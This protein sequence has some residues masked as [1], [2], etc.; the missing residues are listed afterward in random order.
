[1]YAIIFVALFLT[2]ADR[3]LGVDS[4]L[5]P[6]LGASDGSQLVPFHR[7]IPAPPGHRTSASG[8]SARLVVARPSQQI[9][10]SHLRRG[11]LSGRRFQ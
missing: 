7:A 3:Y 10:A 9:L 1:M 5:T 2:S 11:G 4:R 6:R 8:S